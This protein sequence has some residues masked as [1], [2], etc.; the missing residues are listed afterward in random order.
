MNT[1]PEIEPP[2]VECYEDARGDPQPARPHLHLIDFSGETLSNK[3]RRSAAQSSKFA[4]LSLA[5]L[6]ALPPQK[7]MVEGL[8]PE[9]G[10][11]VI[12]GAPG[13]AKTFL[14]L[15]LAF[16]VAS[17]GGEWFGRNVSG[18][19][20]VMVAGEGVQGLAGR[21]RAYCAEKMNTDAE[22]SARLHI[23]PHPPN[24]F[25]GEAD[26]F[27]ESVLPIRPSLVVIDTLARSS[28]G[29]DENSARDMGAVIS[30]ADSIG[31]KMGCLVMLVHHAGKAG[32][33]RGSSALRGAA[34]AMFEV[35][36]HDDGTRELV[37]S[38]ST[39]KMKD[40][41]ESASIFFR[42]QPAGEGESCVVAPAGEP[43]TDVVRP[44]GENQRIVWTI[45]GQAAREATVS[46]EGTPRV[47][48]NNLLSRWQG[49]VK[50]ARKREP[51]ELRR[52]LRSMIESGSVVADCA[53][54]AIT[55]AAKI[56]CP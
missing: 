41:D 29:A 48:F 53:P 21:A 32:G 8:F 50:D 30:A 34:D 14:A 47:E 27:A 36:R 16:C 22:P 4:A 12:Y 54:D 17:G 43:P 3:H 40:A 1:L 44:K 7:W 15:D 10:L 55:G 33:E 51:G 49:V 37:L 24:L 23:V 42:L 11:A 38:G 52:V 20:V 13:S 18:G 45:L 19:P 56:W 46:T 35:R 5:E 31:K 2:P 25:A 6:L 26:E 28:V 39:A 9:R